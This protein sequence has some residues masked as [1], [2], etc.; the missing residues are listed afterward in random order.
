MH[1]TI[2]TV[3]ASGR[4]EFMGGHGTIAGGRKDGLGRSRPRSPSL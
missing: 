1:V 3:G 4:G 2:I